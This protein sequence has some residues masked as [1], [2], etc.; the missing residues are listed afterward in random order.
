MFRAQSCLVVISSLR[1]ETPAANPGFPRPYITNFNL[2]FSQHIGVIPNV[3]HFEVHWK[4][5]DHHDR[6]VFRL[7][8]L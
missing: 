7:I 3:E 2:T 1:L 4:P 6:I 8:L 5:A